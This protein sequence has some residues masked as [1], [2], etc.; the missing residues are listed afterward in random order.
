M[1]SVLIVDDLLSIHEMLEAV[2]QPTGFSTAFA[3][4]GEKALARYKSEKFDLVLADIDMK[5]MDGIALLKQLKA[6]DPRAVVVIMTAYASTE[7][8]VQALKLGAFDYLVKPFKVDELI[9]TLKR[10]LDFREMSSQTVAAG[11]M[12]GGSLDFESQI[13]G[14]SAPVKRL[15]QQIK[16]LVGGKNPILLSGEVGTGKSHTAE[17][18][19]H[20]G[21]SEDAPLVKLD[22]KQNDPEFFRLNLT[23]PDGSG[24][25]SL[26]QAENG[27]LVLHN[28]ECLPRSI[29]KD[30]VKLLRNT[31]IVFRLI[32]TAN[33]DLESL[34]D[35]GKFEEELFY[36]VASLPVHLPALRD[37]IE[38]IPELI[39]HI[40]A[41]C[42]NPNFEPSQIE[43]APD[44]LQAL[45]AYRW[46]GNLA[47]LRQ[48]ISQA[49]STTEERVISAGQLPQ[50][51]LQMDAW[52][53]LDDFLG[54]QEHQ[55]IR[56]VLHSC[57]GDTEAAL[58]ILRCD[59][60]RLEAVAPDNLSA[61]PKPAP[62]QE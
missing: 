37:R 43:F 52:P 42:S 30:L 48:I 7:S 4:D 17:L 45:S 21:A 25:P 47:E 46:P 60:S 3:T 32:C 57:R 26:L 35:E 1:P 31:Q 38:D 10:G 11:V 9:A 15:I 12:P 44:A 53:S 22:C 24:G 55:Y 29:Q 41:E 28:I 58:R 27:T 36:R 62:T 50:R 61:D 40:V 19:H 54:E 14:Q 56:K 13:V 51:I 5:P 33:V 20:G 23:G 16:K 18:I 49:A 8:A 34:V 39:R 59:P 2:I 6:Y